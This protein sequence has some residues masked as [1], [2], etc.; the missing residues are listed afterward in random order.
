MAQE[1]EVEV[2]LDVLV[3][4]QAILGREKSSGGDWQNDIH[5]ALSAFIGEDVG[6]RNTA[7]RDVLA[8]NRASCELSGL[9]ETLIFLQQLSLKVTLHT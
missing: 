4:Y 9:V 8:Q 5:G 1:P 6:C 3:E 2:C 7:Q